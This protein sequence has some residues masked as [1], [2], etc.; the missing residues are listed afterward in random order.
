MRRALAVLAVLVVLTGCVVPPVQDPARHDLTT[1]CRTVRR[2]LGPDPWCEAHY[3][4]AI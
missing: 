1:Y 3:P 4:R 2:L